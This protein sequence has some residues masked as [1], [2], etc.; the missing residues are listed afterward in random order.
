[1]NQPP[2]KRLE[3][4]RGIKHAYEQHHKLKI[5]DEALQAAT[6]L[7]SRYVPDRY[8]PDKAIDVMDEAASRVK[9]YKSPLSIELREVF[10]KTPK[11]QIAASPNQGCRK[12]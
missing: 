3:I 6:R 5:S 9:M 2:I 7:S 11:R 12:A 1:M 10:R 8:L 4:L